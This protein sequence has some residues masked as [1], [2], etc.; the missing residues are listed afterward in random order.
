MNAALTFGIYPGGFAAPGQ[1]GP[2]DDPELINA[3]L[4][5][6]Q[7]THPLVVRAYREFGDNGGGRRETPEGFERCLRHGRTLDLVAQ[8]HSAEGDVDGYRAFVGELIDRYG[9]HISSLQVCEEPNVTD[10]P[11]L[12]GWYP[13]IADAIISGVSAA[14]SHARRVG[15]PGLRVGINTTPLLGKSAGFLAELTARGGDRFIDDLDYI[16]LDFFPDVFRP[17]PEPRLEP[18]VTGMLT[19]HRHDV[20]A[21]AGLGHLPL[22]VTECGWPT[23]PGRSAERQAEVLGSVVGIVARQ[24]SALTIAGYTHFSLRDA[25]SRQPGLLSQFGL[26]TDDYEPKPAFLAYRDLIDRYSRSSGSDGD[27]LDD[28]VT[29]GDVVDRGDLQAGDGGEG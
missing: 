4:D 9:E 19:S 22:V 25:C 10:N 7:G 16:G 3:A 27:A 23:G 24:A 6:L 17:L 15:L 20:L 8:F 1:S 28:H 29:F 26:M 5:E 13:R 21:P 14:K 12:D 11:I 2:P 18:V